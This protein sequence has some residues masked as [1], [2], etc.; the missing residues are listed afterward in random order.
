[1][2]PIVQTRNKVVSADASAEYLS[3]LHKGQT[4][5]LDR[6]KKLADKD[7]EGSLDISPVQFFDMEVAGV[8]PL[9]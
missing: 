7:G 6:L 5:C 9:R 2:T 3:R 8:Y 1:M 4:V